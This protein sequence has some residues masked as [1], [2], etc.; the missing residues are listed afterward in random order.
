MSETPK[1]NFYKDDVA[2]AS[3]SGLNIKTGANIGITAVEDALNNRV[4]ICHSLGWCYF[5]YLH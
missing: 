5:L 4:D 3:Q 1:I 2:V